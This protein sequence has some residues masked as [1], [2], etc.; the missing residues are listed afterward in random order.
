MENG[1]E[2]WRTNENTKRVEDAKSLM[3]DKLIGPFKKNKGMVTDESVNRLDFILG[4]GT[5][6]NEVNVRRG[7]LESPRK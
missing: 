4:E 5:T 6:T 2:N 1:F 3:M 7:S